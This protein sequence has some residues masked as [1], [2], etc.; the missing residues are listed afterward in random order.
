MR[1]RVRQNLVPGNSRSLWTAV[2]CA[3]NI[4]INEMPDIMYINGVLI[5]GKKLP[6]AFADC[7]ANKILNFKSKLLQLTHL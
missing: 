6:V 7:F 1:K 2:S 5:E 3:K 4:N